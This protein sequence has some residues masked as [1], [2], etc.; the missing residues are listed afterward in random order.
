MERFDLSGSV[1]PFT[2]CKK[3]NGMLEPAEGCKDDRLP[4]YLAAVNRLLDAKHAARYRA[5]DLHGETGIYGLL[6][7]AF[8]WHSFRPEHPLLDLRLFR[9]RNL[10]I[11]IITMFLFVSAFFGLGRAPL[12]HS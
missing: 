9:D 2:R 4:P 11:S 6:M 7:A 10:T 12:I 1:R 3:C 5:E 8:V